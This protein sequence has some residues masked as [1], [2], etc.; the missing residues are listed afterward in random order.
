MVYGS[1]PTKCMLRGI[2]VFSYKYEYGMVGC[3]LD[4]LDVALKLVYDHHSPP[5]KMQGDKMEKTQLQD[6][7]IF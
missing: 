3:G 1:P 6:L 2:F 7:L 5:Y 4:S